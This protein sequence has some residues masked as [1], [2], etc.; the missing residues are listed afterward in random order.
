M[1]EKQL[2]GIAKKVFDDLSST[3]KLDESSLFLARIIAVSWDHLTQA[4]K[5]L[6]DEGIIIAGRYGQLKPHPAND[7][8]K[9][10]RRLIMAALK[11]LN[12]TSANNELDMLL[13]D[14]G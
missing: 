9:S 2:T 6:S 14:F 1:K 11:Q 13:G 10:N 12:L 3:Y 5:I 8:A 4:E 7:V